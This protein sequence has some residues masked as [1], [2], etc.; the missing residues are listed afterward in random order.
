MFVFLATINVVLELD[1]D[2]PFC[3]LVADERM[4][5]QMLRVRTLVV[6]LDEDRF[7]EILKLFGPFF[8]LETRRRIAGNEKKGSHRMHVA[9]R[10]LTLGHFKGRDAQTPQIAAIVVRRLRI[11]FAGN[12]F[13][14]HPVRCSDERVAPANR[15]VQLSTHTEIN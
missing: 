12:H 8:R 10:W 7:D 14:S 5:E 1:A 11:V 3:W 9:Q 2:L 15:P 6:I 4:L 13:G